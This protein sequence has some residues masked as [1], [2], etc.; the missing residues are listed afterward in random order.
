MTLPC[1]SCAVTLTVA[2]DIIIFLLE[3]QK[4]VLDEAIIALKKAR[5]TELDVE[6]RIK[7]LA[8]SVAASKRSQ[9]LKKVWSR[10]R[11]AEE[12]DLTP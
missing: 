12:E 4:R 10:K 2:L 1:Y 7:E 5:A 11:K 9:S 8:P 6:A 3:E